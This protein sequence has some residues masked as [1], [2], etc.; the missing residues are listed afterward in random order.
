MVA[1]SAMLLLCGLAIDSGL[2]YLGKA[3]L[4]RAVDGAGLIAVGN[5]NTFGSLDA[6]LDG[7]S[8]IMRN[9]AV[10]NYPSLS[11]IA[12]TPD[13]GFPEGQKQTYTLPNGQ[14]GTTYTFTFSDGGPL[15][16][17]GLHATYVQAVLTTGAGGAITSATCSARCPVHTYFMGMLGA[18]KNLRVSSSAVA[19]RNP[20]LIAVVV[21]RSG[22]MLEV[23]NGQAG[24]AYGLPQAIMTF[25]NF[26]DTTSDY[27]TL[28]SFGSNARLEFPLTTNF[29]TAGT[30]DLYGSYQTNPESGYGIPG[31]DPEQDPTSANY[32]PNYATSGVRRL[33]FGGQTA[34]DEG[35]R[36]GLEQMMDNDGFNNP[37]VV[38][39]MVLFTDGD[40]NACRT[41]ITA[42]G[43]TNIVTGP[44]VLDLH[45]KYLSTN[46]GVPL[47][48]PNTNVVAALNYPGGYYTYFHKDEH[49]NDWFQSVDG[50]TYEPLSGSTTAV[51]GATAT[52]T[53]N[54]FLYTAG[55]TNFYAT[56]INVW[57]Q[58]GSVD[59]VFRSGNVSGGRTPNATY[60]SDFTNP[61]TNF[62]IGLGPGDSNELVVP[63]YLADGVL[64]DGLDLT[65]ADNNAVDGITSGDADPKYRANNY[66]EDYMWPDSN[67][68]SQ[69][70]PPVSVEDSYNGGAATGGET[71]TMRQLM[72]RNYANLLTGYYI[73]RADDPLSGT[74]EPI[75]GAYRPKYG[76]GEYY[77]SIGF[78]F[79][80]DSIGLDP[81]PTE[82]LIDPLTDPNPSCNPVWVDARHITYS[83]NMQSTNAAPNWTGELFYAG[84][85]GTNSVS[86]GTTAQSSLITSATTW[87]NNAPDFLADF[88]PVTEDDTAHDTNSLA[89]VIVLRPSTYN[90]T[91]GGTTNTIPLSSVVPDDPLNKT[92]GYV[93][94]GLG[95]YY[96][97]SMAYSGRPTHYYD[98]SQSKWV[99]IPNNH[100]ADQAAFPLSIWKTKEYCW[101]ARALGVTIYTVGY[102]AAVS[103]DEQV[104]LAE[105]ANATNTTAGAS[106][107]YPDGTNINF[108]S[109]QPIGQQ[110]YATNVTQISNDFYEVGQAISEALTQ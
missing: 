42:P 85:G 39:Y 82:M 80:F 50:S 59:Y 58:P 101:H 33:K 88:A 74:I 66:L 20:R 45:A 43:Y 89:S 87:S 60:V 11:T 19:T 4:S 65:Y 28:V 7:V 36:M 95:N 78:Y 13:E 106:G 83:I 6:N 63:G 53:G 90:G 55:S 110:F 38:K 79:P 5:F 32:D 93:T 29:L 102:G 77:P 105:L 47:L 104:L 8:T 96:R 12:T 40:W 2:L 16:S 15:D 52:V 98:F 91:F 46:V 9:F 1:L 92:G 84:T 107:S 48:E 51:P 30:N 97:N 41:L 109:A 56:N 17:N 68:S 99:P 23:N 57:L 71:S 73:M 25:L 108:N 27:V 22:S 24:G 61:T 26:F 62:T 81:Y 35:I 72:F 18:F 94:D 103:Q 44:S 21:D 86:T 14:S 54:T 49:T 69:E 76:L 37:D 64:Y 100:V 3:R 67:S 75:T 31:V 70:M 10:I 34:A